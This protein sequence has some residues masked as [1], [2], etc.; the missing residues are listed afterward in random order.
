[1]TLA[2]H[3]T[4]RVSTKSLDRMT[5]EEAWSGEKPS[6]ENLKVFGYHTF[7]KQYGNQ[8]K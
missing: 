6:V 1:M 5:L 8:S 2:T 7:M 4:N 3:I